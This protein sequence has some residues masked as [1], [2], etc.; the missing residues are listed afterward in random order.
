MKENK[1]GKLQRMKQQDLLLKMF[2]VYFC[3]I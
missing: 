2:I 1:V 3:M